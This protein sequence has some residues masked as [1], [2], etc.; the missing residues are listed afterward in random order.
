MRRL[1]ACL[2]TMSAQPR[3]SQ[4]ARVRSSPAAGLPRLVSSTCE[5]TGPPPLP[6]VL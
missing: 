2:V 5:V 4:T 6:S 1:A 3:S